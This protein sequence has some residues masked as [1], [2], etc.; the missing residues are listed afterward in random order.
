MRLGWLADLE[1]PSI[2]GG[3]WR[4]RRHVHVWYLELLTSMDPNVLKRSPK[5]SMRLT[6]LLITWGGCH[7][8]GPR[9][10]ENSAGLAVKT[11]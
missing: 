11:V 3:A 5:A 10:L 1:S 8:T 4:H 7:R 2:F 9:C 6:S